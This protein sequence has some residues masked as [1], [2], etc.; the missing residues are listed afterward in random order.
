[1]LLERARELELLDDLLINLRSSGGKVVLIRGEAGIGKTSLVREF[2]ATHADDLHA[3]VGGCDDLLIPQPFAPFWDMARIEPS[4]KGPL[5]DADRPRLLEAVRDLLSRSLRPTVIVIEDTHWADDATLDAIK[6]LGRR[7]AT[8]NGLLVLTYRTGELDYDHPLRGVIGDFPGQDVVR[9]Q[10]GGLSLPAV[11]SIVSDVNLDPEAV[12]A[13][14]KGNPLL[15]K[16]MVSSDGAVIPSSL[17]DSVMARVRKLSPG[18]Q[19]ILMTLAVIPESIPTMDALGLRG[20]SERRLDECERRGLLDVGI[21]MVGF[22]HELTRRAVEAALTGSERLARNRAVLKDLPEETHPCLI[23]HCA[24]EANDVDRLVVVAP[25]SARYAAAMGSHHEA[26]GDFRRLA[27]HLDRLDLED[28]GTLLVEWARE[29]FYVD[30]IAEAV[31][32]NEAALSHYRA[33]G[34][35]RAESRVLA[36][37]AHVYEN[38]GQREQAEKLARQA[39][40]V[41]GDDPDGSDLARALE[42]NAYLQWMAN[43]VTDALELLDRALVA[44]GPDI[45]ERIL[46]RSLNHR[47]M[48]ASVINY[49][50]GRASLDEA[51][52]RSAAAGEWYEECRALFNHAWAAAEHRDL[53]TAEDYVQRAVASAVRHELPHLESYAT[54]MYA[55]ILGL[56]GRWSEAEDLARDQLDGAA[57]SQMVALPIVGT[58]ESRTGRRNAGTTLTKAWEMASVADEFQRLAP[59]AIAVAEH[60]WIT[61]RADVPVA[62]ITSVMESGLE[63]GFRWSPGSIALW[64]WQLGELSEAPAGIAEP[65]RLLIEGKPMAAAERWAEIGCPYERGIALAHGDPTAQLDA[66]EIFDRLGATAV[67]AKLRKALRIE[68]VSVPRG[69]GQKTRDHAAGLTAKQAEVL[70]LLD[71]GLSNT[72]IADR[73]FVSPRT[74]EHHVSAILAKLDSSNRAEAVEA[75][76]RQGLLAPR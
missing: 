22:R 24:V 67:A 29:E 66:L 40:D 71:E 54:A 31:R 44:A 63:K 33:T 68:G 64:L 70:E 45:E 47:G 21:E 25:R 9:I 17:Q 10:L 14:T 5:D 55:R 35:R 4:L 69:K 57:I 39:V 11:S 50:D 26:V 6:Y 49:P 1:M 32:L 61:D 52:D 3:H 53:P 16:E 2:L 43:N 41:L 12:L 56:R 74:V 76:V 42:V 60:A 28:R 19:Q 20:A 13:A 15:V 36:Q 48:V 30:N 65:Y 18:A 51:R 37:A 62:A 75:A 72:E 73:L 58:I 38:A 23:I 7:I 34:D 8:A 46:I 59:T 27:P